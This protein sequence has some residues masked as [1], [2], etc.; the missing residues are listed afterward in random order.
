MG[1][2]KPYR[3][4]L[5]LPSPSFS[6][7]TFLPRSRAGVVLRVQPRWRGGPA[8]ESAAVRA[9]VREAGSASLYAATSPVPPGSPRQL[10]QSDTGVPHFALDPL[11]YRCLLSLSPAADFA[12]P[13]PPSPHMCILCKVYIV[14]CVYWCLIY[15]EHFSYIVVSTVTAQNLVPKNFTISTLVYM[16]DN[17]E[18]W[19]ER[20][21]CVA[22]Y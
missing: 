22:A 13:R 12:E 15:I 18:I 14:V 8:L 3:P 1:L 21:S 9:H 4:S 6:P 17:K 19:F 7:P 11:T 5:S 20:G 10:L 2:A 16:C